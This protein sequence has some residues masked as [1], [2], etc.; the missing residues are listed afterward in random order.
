[1][2]LLFSYQ[3]HPA[4]FALRST[5]SFCNQT[6][7][8]NWS[9]SAEY[10]AIRRL[11]RKKRDQFSSSLA[12]FRSIQ[13]PHGFFIVAATRYGGHLHA[14]DHAHLHQGSR[15]RK[16]NSWRRSANDTNKRHHAWDGWG[17]FVSN[18]TRLHTPPAHNHNHPN[19]PPNSKPYWEKSNLQNTNT[20]L[21]QICNLFCHL[22]LNENT[23]SIA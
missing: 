12:S 4:S 2:T 13:I 14:W 19:T 10:S 6:L 22:M 1:M 23:P 17:G 18:T 7:N 20:N 21:M 11:Q 15:P 5:I 16:R 8:G 3:N 9:R